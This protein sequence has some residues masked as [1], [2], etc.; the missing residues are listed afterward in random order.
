MFA[1]LKNSLLRSR[2][3]QDWNY[4]KEAQLRYLSQSAQLEESGNPWLVRI[5]VLFISAFVLLFVVWASIAEVDEVSRAP[6]EII[7]EGFQQSIQHLEGGII[8]EIFVQEGMLV[9]AGQ[10]LVTLSKEG[11]E[12]DKVRLEHKLRLLE[13]Q[14][15]RYSAAISGE[16]LQLGHVEG[17]SVSDAQKQY[18]MYK[19]MKGA[20][21]S[22]MAMVQKQVNQKQQAIEILKTK[23][24]TIQSRL[25]V[26]E[27]LYKK[28]KKLFDQGYFS[29]VKL[30]AIEDE[31]IVLKGQ[32]KELENQI[33]QSQSAVSEF[34][35]KL[36]A[37]N[38][39]QRD[40]VHKDLERVQAEMQQSKEQLEKLKARIKRLVIRAPERGVVKGLAVSTIGG[41]VRPAQVLMEIIPLEYNL[42]AEVKI[43]PSDVG[44][45]TVGD[46]VKVKVSAY[47]FAKYGSLNGELFSLSATTFVGEDGARY[48]KGRVKLAKN[49]V[50]QQPGR[51]MVIPG[52]TV[53]ADI[54][55][56]QRSIMS[57]L[58]K[59]IHMSLQSAFQEK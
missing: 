41:V 48:Y 30:M 21:T 18:Q 1:K 29:Q 8:E 59:P 14:E 50:G 15:A 49:Y 23:R 22:E 25:K 38:A 43:A 34:K 44:N 24:D 55:T 54:V 53:M 3:V 6:G 7:P 26:L 4:N 58:F 46:H 37:I 39:T 13:L 5:T 42:T 20:N 2:I 27:D 9:E 19:E 28:R 45:L 31:L 51:N 16:G 17:L 47:D 12:T 57:Y 40:V 10:P 56:G 32:E 33:K 35:D 52:M 36:N 11:L